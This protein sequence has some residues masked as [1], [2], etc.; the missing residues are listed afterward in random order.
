MAWLYMPCRPQWQHLLDQSV[1]IRDAL[2]KSDAVHVL[3]SEGAG[4]NETI[5]VSCCTPEKVIWQ[6]LKANLT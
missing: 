2:I 4:G 5:V 1:W 6:G 3:A